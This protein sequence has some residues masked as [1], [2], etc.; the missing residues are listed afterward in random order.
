M[1]TEVEILRDALVS[2]REWISHWM[3]DKECNL[4]PTDSSL[5][6]AKAEIEVA[7]RITTSAQPINVYARLE[8]AYGVRHD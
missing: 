4:S 2:Q 1:K 5:A 6:S 8:E 3:K 7:L